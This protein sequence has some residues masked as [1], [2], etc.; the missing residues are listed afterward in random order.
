MI[1]WPGL[2]FTA[3]FGF[4]QL[5]S[6]RWGP[7]TYNVTTATLTSITHYLNGTSLRADMYHG[8]RGTVLGTFVQPLQIQND[9]KQV[10]VVLLKTAS[11]NYMVQ[12]EHCTTQWWAQ[13]MTVSCYDKQKF[14][15]H[16]E[17]QHQT[18]ACKNETNWRVIC[19]NHLR[20]AKCEQ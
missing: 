4:D 17:N 5:N 18:A 20:G 11:K 13:S 7:F 6:T 3:I 19:I 1:S 15:C 12:M 14:L 10:H 9:R 2:I 8:R 16:H